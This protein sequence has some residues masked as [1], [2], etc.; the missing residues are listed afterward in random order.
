MLDSETRKKLVQIQGDQIGE[1][2]KNVS[3]SEVLNQ[4]LQKGL[5]NE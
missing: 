2:H 4:V 1:Y 5:K 3:F